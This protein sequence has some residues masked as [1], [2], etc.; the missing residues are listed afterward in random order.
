MALIGGVSFSEKFFF[1]K[2][3]AVMLKS[4]IPIA[5]IVETL[6]DQAKSGTFKK[7]LLQVKEDVSRGRSL[8][9]SLSSYPKV[10]DQFYLS[11]VK[12]GESSGTLE[13]SLFYLVQQL[14]KERDLRQ[15]VQ[16]AMLYPAIVLIATGGI[17]LALAFFILPQIIGLFE[18]LNVQLPFTTK[19]LIFGARLLQ[20]WGLIIIPSAIGLLVLLGIVLQLRLVKPHWHALL[21]RLPIF[22]KLLQGISLATLARNLGIMLKSGLTITSA[23]ETSAQVERNLVY[24]RDLAKVAEEVRKGKSIEDILVENNFKEFPLFMVRMIGVGEKSG[25][26][27]ENLAYLGDYFED[28]VDTITKNLSTILEPVLLIVIGGMVAFVALSIISPIYQVTGSIR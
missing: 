26:L 28:E 20:D 2:N 18:S 3:L 14:Q 16:G 25:N 13:E 27:E 9:K 12:V 21:L 17:G 15:K 24:K 5:S 22:G 7:I 4:G 1:T 6:G 11:L 19:A 23:L 8:E 10:F